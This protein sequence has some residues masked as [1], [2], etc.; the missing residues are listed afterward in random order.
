ML[1]LLRNLT[2]KKDKSF[3]AQPNLLNNINKGLIIEENLLDPEG[4]TLF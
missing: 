4:L 1:R 2:E 3:F